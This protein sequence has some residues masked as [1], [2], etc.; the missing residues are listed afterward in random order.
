MKLW[1]LKYWDSGEYQVVDER[2]KAMEKINAKIG[3]D[4]YNP[5]RKSLFKSLQIIS[6]EEVRVAIIG[7][8]PYPAPAFSTGIAFSIP[9]L[10]SGTNTGASLRSILPKEFPLTL[11]CFL[12]EY[13]TDLGY[14]LP[15][16]GDL[17]QWS[18]RGV[19]LWNA[20]PSC[21][22]GR[23]LS[24]DWTE[25]SYLTKEIVQRLSKR[26]IVFAFLGQVARRFLGDVDLSNNEVIVT[27]H[28]SPRGNLNSKSPFIGS[29]LFST[30]NDK[31]VSNGQQPIDWKL[32]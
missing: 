15:D 10:Y 1:G 21:A 23:S 4:G 11:R 20:I 16:N 26:G 19:F 29:R 8:D 30:I 17:S 28:P 7:Q 18:A 31:L 2:L 14:D 12:K 22:S 3:S 6:P 25:Y 9:K 5:G 13:N 27:S 32:K 24:H